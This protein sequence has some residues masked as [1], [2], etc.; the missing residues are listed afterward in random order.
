MTNA[1]AELDDPDDAPTPRWVPGTS[2]EASEGMLNFGGE[3]DYAARQ[4]AREMYESARERCEILGGYATHTPAKQYLTIVPAME[5]GAVRAHYEHDDALGHPIV[6][7]IECMDRDRDVAAEYR[8]TELRRNGKRV[9]ELLGTDRE[10]EAVPARCDLCTVAPLPVA[11]FET[12]DGRQVC[13]DHANAL[14]SGQW[15][16]APVTTTPIDVDD[17]E[18][19]GAA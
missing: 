3:H 14:E 19:E 11:R 5:S 18:T 12:D 8:V 17:A 9:A 1:L 10:S 7:R 4:D 13:G 15:G 16:D 6:T 2:H